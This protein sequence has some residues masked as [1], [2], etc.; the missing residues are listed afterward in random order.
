M[1]KAILQ[2]RQSLHTATC[3]SR[4]HFFLTVGETFSEMRG[5]MKTQ[6]CDTISN[7]VQ[8]WNVEFI[9]SEKCTTTCT[10]M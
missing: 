2:E 9:T 6:N 7:S 1:F 5:V 8:N 3:I 4:N 10:C